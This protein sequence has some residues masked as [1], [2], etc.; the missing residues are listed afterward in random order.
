[1]KLTLSL[2]AGLPA[3][4]GNS[5]AANHH[6]SLGGGGSGTSPPGMNCDS[7][8]GGFTR[9]AQHGTVLGRR[10]EWIRLDHAAMSTTPAAASRAHYRRPGWGSSRD[11]N[12][13]RRGQGEGGGG[14]IRYRGCAQAGRAA[15]QE[16]SR[17]RR[18]RGRTGEEKRVGG[19][20]REGGGGRIFDGP[21]KALTP[22]LDR[23]Q[24]DPTYDAGI[25]VFRATRPGPFT[26]KFPR[27]RN[28]RMIGPGA[29]R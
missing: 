14:T 29:P 7:R 27:L 26:P 13:R 8:G 11:D 19:G 1:M 18:A 3:A 5:Q 22:N 16:G 28:S 2:V 12:P 21:N 20:R 23:V 25:D 10:E 6:H 4:A 17:G 9:S 15:V 24:I